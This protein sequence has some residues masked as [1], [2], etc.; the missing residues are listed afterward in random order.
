M[1]RSLAFTAVLSLPLVAQA[2]DAFEPTLRTKALVSAAAGGGVVSKH[3]EAPFTVG[4]DP[5]PQLMRL[6]G[7]EHQGPRAACDTSSK[8]LC[9]DLA[10]ARI[11]YRP[12]RN[13]MP[14]VQGLTPE[15]VSLRRNKLVLKYS[16]R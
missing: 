5:L 7:E 10:D 14:S 16:F 3:A 12:A 2:I 4:R 9:Y 8:D 6:E 11:V 15:S 13:Y 1:L